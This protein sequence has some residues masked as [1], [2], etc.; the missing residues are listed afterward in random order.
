MLKIALL[1]VLFAASQVA[2]FNCETHTFTQCADNIVH[3][4]DPDD[5][6][7]GSH[8]SRTRMKLINDNSDLRPS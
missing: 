6:M 3:W 8:H 2:A 5:G 1:P 7:V 4:Y